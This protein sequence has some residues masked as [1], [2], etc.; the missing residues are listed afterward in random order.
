MDS[1]QLKDFLDLGS[2]GLLTFF[3]WQ[4]WSR[5]NK[6]TDM[7]FEDRKQAAAERAVIAR[8]NGLDTQG[9][10]Q[11]VAEVQSRRKDA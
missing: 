8:Q 4:V 6:V 10:A 3:L 2:N 9:L 5:L 11:A 1:W 7:F